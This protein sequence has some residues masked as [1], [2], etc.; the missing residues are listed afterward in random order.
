MHVRVHLFAVAR[1]RA[2]RP[3]VEVDLPGGSTV[4]GLKAALGDQL[5]DLAPI[6]PTARFAV[7]AEYA[8]DATPIP[9]GAEVALIPPVSGGS[10]GPLSR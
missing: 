7:D 2:G 1:Q 5:P 3:V 10:E 8:D 4:A 9:P 6:L